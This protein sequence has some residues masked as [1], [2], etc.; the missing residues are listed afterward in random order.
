MKK[1][2]IVSTLGP[3]SNDLKIISALIN[4]GINVARFNFSHG[5]H[6]EHAARMALVH[7]AE[8]KT[9]KL[10][11]FMLDTKGAEIRTT[12]QDTPNGKI[13]FKKGDRLRISMNEKIKGT[14]EK[15]AVTYKGL[16][17]DV[18]VGGKVL[19]DDGIIEMTV[20]SKDSEKKEL[21]VQVDN[22]GVLGGRKGVN[23]PGV[24]INLPG[25]T[26]KDKSDIEFG[27][28][29]GID[30]IAASFVRKAQD[31][32]DIR[33]LLKKHHQENHVMI[34]PKIESQEGIDN[35][36][37]II[38]VSDG[39]MVPRG[40]MGVEIPYEEVPVIQKMMI[41]YMNRLGKPV[42]TAT[43]MLDSMIENPR[44]T[45][46]EI[47]DVENAVWDG[48][49][50][51]ML[52][53]ESANGSWPVEAVKTMSTSDEYAENHVH[54]DGNRIDLRNEPKS[55]DTEVLAQAAVD[56][57]REAGA[58]AI[59]ASTA[60]DYTARLIS[61]YRPDMPILAITYDEKVARSLTVNYAVY[62]VVKDAPETTDDLI[63]LA[64]KTVHDEKLAKR[65]DTIVVTAGLPIKN[66]GTTNLI[67]VVKL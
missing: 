52:S 28:E 48:T 67:H 58:K 40:D 60:S 9:G 13:E 56:A 24:A 35:F 33:K 30:F 23:A 36:E 19:F 53:G 27:L 4:N 49:D 45:R 26:K 55:S 14:K 54:D 42:I 65:D 41:R 18:K 44:A 11:G 7:D 63:E 32:L 12:V 43:Q 1:T 50:A 38:A 39:L 2:K 66:P 16:Y 57:A 46:A 17:D 59:V 10:I 6:D 31:V 3:A 37:S 15:I 47:N 8:K 29:Q 34:F 62:P 25:I 61:K 22:D 51:T 20:I 5:D 64:K 21:L